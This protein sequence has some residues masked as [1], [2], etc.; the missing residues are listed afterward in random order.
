[1]EAEM[2]VHSVQDDS[3]AGFEIHIDEQERIVDVAGE[4][5]GPGGE[6]KI[7]GPL[8]THTSVEGAPEHIRAFATQ[9]GLDV[10]YY[11]PDHCRTCYCDEKGGMRCVGMC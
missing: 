2:A 10:C 7:A 9:H 4:W 1:M 8:P 5:S 6:F 11:D 3:G